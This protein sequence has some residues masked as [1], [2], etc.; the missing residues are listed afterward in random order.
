MIRNARVRSGVARRMKAWMFIATLLI[1]SVG[2]V[3][4]VVAKQN[5]D[6]ERHLQ[7]CFTRWRGEYDWCQ[8][9][10]GDL[11]EVGMAYCLDGAMWN[12]ILCASWGARYVYAGWGSQL[13]D[14]LEGGQSAALILLGNAEVTGF[15]NATDGAG[16]LL[17]ALTRHAGEGAVT[18]EDSRLGLEQP[19]AQLSRPGQ[20]PAAEAMTWSGVKARVK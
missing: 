5:D 4:E 1:P 18:V 8:S 15:L 20:R 16:A 11:T 10:E 12:Y 17:N 14:D 7:Y 13:S 2:V 6:Y 3:G 9:H 19:R